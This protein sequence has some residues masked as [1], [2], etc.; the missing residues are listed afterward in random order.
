MTDVVEELTPHTARERLVER[1]TAKGVITRPEVAAAFLAVP[2]HLFAPPGTSLQAAY[3]DDVVITKKD[4]DGKAT[5]SISAPWLQATMLET[6]R[7]GPGLRVL[8]IGSGGY[9]AALIAEIVGPTGAVT[10]ID[11]DADVVTNAQAALTRAGY[12]QV[13]VAQADAEYGYSD[14]GPYD[15]LIVT[16]E[17]GDIPPAWTQQ[18]AP[19]G[20][21]VVP[22]RMRGNTRCLTLEDHGD[23]LA[24][25]TSLQC[26]FVAMQ[27]DGSNPARRVH[28]R[29]DAIVLVLDDTTQVN[30]D[31]L[32]S[33]LDLPRREVWSPVTVT[34]DESASFE[35]LHLW[36]ASQP[37]PY[38]VLAVDRER[39]AGL[40]D[41]DNKFVCP[42]LLTADS[43]AYLTL[44]KLDDTTWRFGAHGFGP[45]ATALVAD[46]VDLIAAWDA[47]HRHGPGP[48]ITVHPAD[49]VLPETDLARLLVRR[50]HTMIAITW[51]GG[52]SA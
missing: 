10:S 9:N 18:L 40:L 12:P 39:T 42:T 6:A 32:A 28:L 21:M 16:V 14:A 35:S 13:H 29:G 31:T 1:L 49:T 23:H 34:M 51:P 50:R 22:L 46:L 8:E 2:R 20:R 17:T 25:T 27:G 43:F 44:G 45:D 41:P 5:S 52:A 33:A 48:R 3:A 4:A 30:A 24:A 38:G 37:R 11:I 19:G 15:A 47:H 7:L 36:L 26:G